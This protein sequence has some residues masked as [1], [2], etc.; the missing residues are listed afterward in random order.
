MCDW[1]FLPF[2]ISADQAHACHPNYAN[3][4]EDCHKPTFNKGV[5]V[6]INAN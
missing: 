3:K 6:K 2:M 1:P 4:H 5:V